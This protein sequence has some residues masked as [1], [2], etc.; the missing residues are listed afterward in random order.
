MWLPYLLM[1]ITIIIMIIFI[2][3]KLSYGF[4]YYQPVFHLY[5]IRYYFFPCGIIEHGLPEMNKY[6]N[7]RE[8]ETVTFDQVLKN[9][10]KLD[11]L[12]N[13]VQSNYLRNAQN[14]FC[15]KK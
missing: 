4:W 10:H 3:L 11:D 13:I 12:I 15:P 6:T 1:F 5:D 8:I 2:F 7:L 14:I 9:S